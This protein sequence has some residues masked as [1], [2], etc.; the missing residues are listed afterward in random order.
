[1]RSAVGCIPDLDY[2]LRTSDGYSHFEFEIPLTQD[3]CERA[4]FG[5][6]SC[7]ASW[8]PNDLRQCMLGHR[9]ANR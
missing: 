4:G 2:Y 8:I 5:S 3:S 9:P 7:S 6:L 1:M